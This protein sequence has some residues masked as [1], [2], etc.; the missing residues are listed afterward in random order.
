M[1]VGSYGSNGWLFVDGFIIRKARQFCKL[2]DLNI[3]EDFIWVLHYLRKRS[4]SSA[5]CMSIK[6]A[7]IDPG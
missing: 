4:G 1:K 6:W 3:I 5:F 2:A 7:V